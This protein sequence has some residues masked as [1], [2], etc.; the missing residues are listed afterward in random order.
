MKAWIGVQSRSPSGAP[1]FSTEGSAAL[2]A[3]KAAME[4]PDDS[5]IRSMALYCAPSTAEMPISSATA[6]TATMARVRRTCSGR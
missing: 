6:V 5:A 1:A 4:E 2:L 3:T